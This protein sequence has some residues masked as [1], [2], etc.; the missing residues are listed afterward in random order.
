MGY[1]S[2]TALMRPS[3]DGTLGA[4]RRALPLLGDRFLVLYGDTYLRIDYAAVARSWR[5]SGLPAVMTVL[6]NE[7]RW[8]TSNV[9]YRD[10]MVVHYDKR[11]PTPDMRWIDYGL[12]GLTRGALDRMP[13][14]EDDL[15][16]LYARL[17]EK[18][19]LL[20]FEATERFYE[21]GTPRALA[22]TEAFLLGLTQ[23]SRPGA[24]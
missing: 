9:I 20:G 6:R 14:S 3:L 8:D 24:R 7:G 18:G 16:A 12:G 22:E 21:I 17:A 23:P 11:A 2:N 10:R 4:V 19:E 15:S 13:T 1:V 5:E